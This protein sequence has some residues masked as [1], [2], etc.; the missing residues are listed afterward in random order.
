MKLTDY[1]EDVGRPV[2][3]YPRLAPFLGSV[4]ATLFLC[5]LLFWEGKQRDKVER[6]IYKTQDEI[7]KETG[8]SRREQESARK[9]LRERGYLDEKYQGIP[10][11]LF[12]RI[13][14]D[15]I[16]RDWDKWIEQVANLH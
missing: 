6:W 15:A 2:A 4:K 3:Y 11:Q 10:R 9:Q 13:N 14:L 8:L 16:N 5:Q 7:Q 1:F 12:F